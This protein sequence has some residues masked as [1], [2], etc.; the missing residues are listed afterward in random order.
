[1]GV[2]GTDIV[3]ALS[4]PAPIL[5]IYTKNPTHDTTAHLCIS[6]TRNGLTEKPVCAAE[7]K[8]RNFKSVRK[9]TTGFVGLNS[10]RECEQ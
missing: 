2:C 1:M 3:N 7:I 9:T 5:R 4:P 8:L 10:F 6:C